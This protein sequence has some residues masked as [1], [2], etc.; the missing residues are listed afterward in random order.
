LTEGELLDAAQA[1]KIYEDIVRR[2]LDPALF[3][4]SDQNLFRVRIFPFEPGKTKQIRLRY[5][6]LL[7]KDGNLVNFSLPLKPREHSLD[8]DDGPNG[9]FSLKV[10]LAS[11]KGQK[12]RSIYSPSHDIDIDYANKKSE[13]KVTFANSNESPVTDFQLLFSSVSK[14][15][16]ATPISAEFF[17][18][19]DNDKKSEGHFLLLVS[20][21][22]WLEN[23]ELPV[24]PKDVV[25]VLDSSASM[26]DGKL[27]KAKEGLD[28]CLDSLNP[29]DRFQIVRFSTDSE[30]LFKKLVP[31]SKK[32]RNKAEKFVNAIKPIGGTAV[33]EAL[34]LAIDNLKKTSN[35]KR[36][37]RQIV[38][39]TDGQP[40]LGATD[41]R[42]L[43]NGVERQLK[44]SGENARVFCFGIGSDINTHLLDR[45][46]RATNADAQ[47]ALPSEDIEHKISQFYSKFAEPVYSDLSIDIAGVDWIRSQTP[48]VLPDL[49]RGDQLVILGR[50]KRADDKGKLLLKGT[51]RG[52]EESFTFPLSL[53]RT[54]KQNRFIPRL[55]AVRRVGWLLEQIRLNGESDELKAEVTALAREY[56]IVTPYTSWL[57]LED[58]ARRNVP[59]THRSLRDFDNAPVRRS[60]LG[61]KADAFENSKSGDDALA[62]AASEVDLKG[63][64]NISAQSRATLRSRFSAGGTAAPIETQS[65]LINGKSF[66]W[67]SGQWVDSASQSLPADVPVKQIE[68]GSKDYFSF[69]EENPAACQW[70][71]AGNNL[72]LAISSEQII[73]ITN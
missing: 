64:Q 68:F 5:T 31:A 17:T 1:R 21:E 15:E 50:F 51:F 26:R 29:E 72:R 63:A 70:F 44:D 39:I 33:E 20:P 69:L 53:T 37:P 14:D 13:A 38:F 18:H 42:V 67:N 59:M 36:R 32:N 40:T 9:K 24:Q 65:C 30:T 41:E 2:T 34:A 58:E 56:A 16:K 57:I 43:V 23:Q 35:E 55:W 45:L 22:V 71:S 66:Y 6:Q 47:F 19:Y 10:S 11:S 4:Y 49:F 28:F 52:E 8:S 73:E 54:G 3:E 62:A 12:F 60:E 7:P 46:A 25:F 27:N 48:K 61:A